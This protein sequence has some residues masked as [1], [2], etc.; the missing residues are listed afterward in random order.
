[1]MANHPHACS[2]FIVGPYSSKPHN[3]GEATLNFR[4]FLSNP[5]VRSGGMFANGAEELLIP[6]YESHYCLAIVFGDIFS[7]IAGCLFDFSAE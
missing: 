1:M 7:L 5:L 2:I 6:R 4:E 3:S